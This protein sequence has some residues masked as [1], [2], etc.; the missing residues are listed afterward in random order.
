MDSYVYGAD[1]YVFGTKVHKID[2]KNRIAI[3][4][5][6]RSFLGQEFVI[7]MGLG[8]YIAIYPMH[9]WNSYLTKIKN[10]KLPTTRKEY[11]A[12]RVSAGAERTTLDAQGRVVLSEKLQKYAHIFNEHEAEVIGN[13]NHIE[14]WKVKEEEEF[15]E[16]IGDLMDEVD[17]SYQN[18]YEMLGFGG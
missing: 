2:S 5:S 3:P 4:A 12:R 17:A 1:N 7:S 11:I 14:I 8:E 13:I 6:M 18:E 15:N 9:E 16:S 10:S